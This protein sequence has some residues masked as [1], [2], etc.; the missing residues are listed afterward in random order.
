MIKIYSQ[1]IVRWYFILIPLIFFPFSCKVE[2]NEN[3]KIA[4][5][6]KYK[7]ENKKADKEEHNF[8]QFIDYVYAEYYEPV[9][10]DLAQIKERGKL[11][12][13]TGYSHTSYFV[14]KGT[15]M[16]FEHDLLQL[17]AKELK[18][19]LEIIV[20]H[21][22]NEILDMLNR[23]EGDIIADNL[24]ITKERD[25]LVNFT[26]PLHNTRQVLVQKNQTTGKK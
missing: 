23:G 18:V 15:P 3:A 5:E 12:A 7:S 4:G 25:A 22:M 26:K 9:N 24:T 17:L 19:E 20:V 10:I 21:D 6:A 16:G 13:L 1:K 2:I 8:N 14:Y 11:I